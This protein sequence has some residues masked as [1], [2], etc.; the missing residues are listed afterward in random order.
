M[1][2]IRLVTNNDIGPGLEV[3]GSNQ[4]VPKVDG[5]TVTVNASGELEAVAKLDVKLQGAELDGNTLRLTLSDNNTV[6]ADL[7]TLLNTDTKVD[8]ITLAGTVA[9]F[10]MSDGTSKTLELAPLLDAFKGDEVQ[11]LGGTKLGHFVKA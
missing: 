8:T 5:T 1:A 10:A 4:L 3:N 2:I 11:S 7:A 6:E 9:T